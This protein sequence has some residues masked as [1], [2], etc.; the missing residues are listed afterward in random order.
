MSILAEYEYRVAVPAD[1][2]ALK[3]LVDGA[4]RGDSARRGWT[5]E[6]DL[7]D[8]QRIGE[9]GLAVIIADPRQD[10]LLA[11]SGG[12]LIG[13]VQVTSVGEGRAYLGLLAVD[14]ERQAAGLGRALIGEAERRAA[15]QFAAVCMEMTVI[16]QRVDLIAYY[17][18]RGYV[19]TGEERP[20]PHNDCRVQ[21]GSEPLAFAVLEK[22]LAVL[23]A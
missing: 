10:I 8:D 6:A 4:Y 9:Q 18:R 23:A 7:L 22:R 15:L 14:P 12:I 20:F 5:H 1:V 16:K 2:T 13:C 17:H 3:T 11:F 19:A 21:A